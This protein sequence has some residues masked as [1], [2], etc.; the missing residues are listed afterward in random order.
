M[1]FT[2]LDRL[3]V[4]DLPDGTPQ[5]LTNQDVGEYFPTWSPDGQAI[6]VGGADGA[7]HVVP[8]DPKAD[9]RSFDLHSD[10]VLD[11]AYTPDGKMLVSGGRDKTTKV[12]SVETGQLLRSVDSS[13]ELISSVAADEQFAV[14]AGKARA[15]T[16]YELKTALSGIEQALWD[17]MGQHLGVPI[18]T[19]F[20]GTINRHITSLLPVLINLILIPQ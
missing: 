2:A 16:G 7:V 18:H 19:L 13:S 17:I 12:C 9:V 15:L 11:V 5:R 10:W 8:V 1:A 20:G 4:M 14:T 3:Y 6:A